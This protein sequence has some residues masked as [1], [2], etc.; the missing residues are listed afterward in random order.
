MDIITKINKQGIF[1]I[2]QLDNKLLCKPRMFMIKQN[3]MYIV[4]NN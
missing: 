3:K 4:K 1:F 2:I